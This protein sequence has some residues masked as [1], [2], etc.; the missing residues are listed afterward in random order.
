[1]QEVKTD[2]GLTIRIPNSGKV[3]PGSNYAAY[4]QYL[5]ERALHFIETKHPKYPVDTIQ[6]LVLDQ[7]L[8][9]GVDLDWT[10][11][12]SRFKAGVVDWCENSFDYKIAFIHIGKVR[13]IETSLLGRE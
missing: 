7:L 12:K 4:L 3:K 5:G 10:N 1:M 8:K 2:I 6:Y 9:G 11:S 13:R